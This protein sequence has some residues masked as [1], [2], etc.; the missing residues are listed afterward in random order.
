M[1]WTVWLVGSLVAVLP[2]VI[3]MRAG[4]L[5]VVRA[6]LAVCLLLLLAWV[7]G[8]A[9]LAGP[10]YADWPRMLLSMLV[11]GTLILLLWGTQRDR[12]R[13][14]GSQAERDAL[15]TGAF[16]YG[17]SQTHDSGT[18]GDMGDAGGGGF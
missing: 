10:A 6:Y 2:G 7:F 18:G 11:P 5:K 12:R 14:M 8:L 17:A 4:K 9:A 15:A 16:I 1:S 3:L 13:V